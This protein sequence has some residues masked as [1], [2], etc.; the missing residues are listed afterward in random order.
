MFRVRKN[1]NSKISAKFFFSNLVIYASQYVYYLCKLVQF[2]LKLHEGLRTNNKNKKVNNLGFLKFVK[3]LEQNF[4]QIFFSN[5]VIYTPQYVY[6]LY[7]LVQF[8][9]K[10]H[11]DSEPTITTTKF[12]IQHTLEFVKILEQS[13]RQI[14]FSILVI[15]ASQ[16]VYYLCKLVQFQLKLHGDS[17]PTITKFKIQHV[18]SS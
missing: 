7:K 13:F 9:L 3:I 10:L 16:Y 15:Y 8:Q 17:E 1:S 11:G 5:L 6:Y 12:K 2:Q 18:Q 4:R 14:F